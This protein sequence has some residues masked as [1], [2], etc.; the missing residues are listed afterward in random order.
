M[1]VGVFMKLAALFKRVTSV[2]LAAVLTASLFPAPLVALAQVRAQE[3]EQ[4]SSSAAAPRYNLDV[5]VGA[6]VAQVTVD[7]S[8]DGVP[9]IYEEDVEGSVV[10]LPDENYVPD[11]DL[12]AAENFVRPMV[13][14]E[15]AEKGLSVFSSEMAIALPSVSSTSGKVYK[16]ISSVELYTILD[17][18]PQLAEELPTGALDNYVAY[19]TSAH[20]PSFFA[21]LVSTTASSVTVRE[22]FGGQ[23]TL[24]F[25]LA[26][27]DNG[28]STPDFLASLASL[29]GYQEGRATA[30]GN[31]VKLS[32]FLDGSAVIQAGN[33]LQGDLATK[34]VRA[35][36]AFDASGAMVSNRDMAAASVKIVFD[37]RSVLGGTVSG[38]S[39]SV[40]GVSVPY[41]YCGYSL[42][43][44][45][46]AVARVSDHIQA[47]AYLDYFSAFT[48]ANLD[49]RVQREYWVSAVQANASRVARDILSNSGALI[50]T[51]PDNKVY[52]ALLDK[53]LGT[54]GTPAELKMMSLL[55]TYNYIQRWYDFDVEGIHVA[56][57]LLFGGSYYGE[58]CT[59][60]GLAARFAVSQPSQ[61]KGQQTQ[62]GY[63]QLIYPCLRQG[64]AIANVK[65]FVEDI[66]DVFSDFETADDWFV[67]EYNKTG[68]V[69]EGK[70]SEDGFSW[71]A[72][73]NLSK[74][75]TSGHVRNGQ[76]RILPFLTLPDYSYYAF[77][78][79][80]VFSYGSPYMYYTDPSTPE[81]QAAL[82]ARVRKNQQLQL[83]YIETIVGFTGR[84]AMWNAMLFL[85]QDKQI[86]NAWYGN[87]AWQAWWGENGCTEANATQDPMIKG[88]YEALQLPPPS[89]GSAACGG[90][91]IVR[92]RCNAKLDDF[93]VWSHEFGHCIDEKIL[94]GGATRKDVA[95][96]YTFGMLE[97][98]L[99]SSAFGLNIAYDSPWENAYSMNASFKSLRTSDSAK[100]FYGGLFELIDIL[101]YLELKAFLRLSTA[102]QQA[103]ATQLW[104]GGDNRMTG[105]YGGP[106]FILYDPASVSKFAS[107]MNVYVSDEAKA[108]IMVDGE[109]VRH[110]DTI[111]EV[112]DHRVCLIPNVTATKHPEWGPSAYGRDTILSRWWYLP[113]HNNGGSATAVYKSLSF[114]MA[115]EAGYYGF[116]QMLA[117]N[118][119]DT[120]ALRNATG[121]QDFK[122]YKLDT[123][124]EIEERLDELRWIDAD[125]LEERYLAAFKSAAAKGDRSLTEANNI[126]L[127]SFALLKRLTRDF[128]DTLFSPT[129]EATHIA[130]AADLAKIVE[131][132][133]GAFVL[134]NDIRVT[135]EEGA[136]FLVDANFRG[137]FNGQGHSITG[138]LLPPLF[139]EADRATVRDLTINDSS[140]ST[141]AVKMSNVNIWNVNILVRDTSIAISNVEEFLAM[142]N[143][144]AA[145][146][147]I[148]ADIDFSDHVVAAAGSALIAA[149]FTGSLVGDGHVLSGLT[150][151]SLFTKFKGT[152]R[153]LQIRDFTNK[154]VN[155]DYIA[156]FAKILTGA[157]IENISFANIE[158]AGKYRTAVLCGHDDSPSAIS[159]VSVVNSTVTGQD[160][161]CYNSLLVGR[162]NGGTMTDVHVQ[163]QLICQGTENGGVCGSAKATVFTRCVA[164]VDITRLP[165]ATEERIQSAGFLGNFDNNTACTVK[166]CAFVG[167]ADGECYGFTG[168]TDANKRYFTDCYE[169]EG[170]QATSAVNG[171]NIKTLSRSDAVA[172]QFWDGLGY[173]QGLWSYADISSGNPMLVFS[174]KAWDIHMSIDYIA[175]TMTLRGED[176]ENLNIDGLWGVT[177]GMTSVSLTQALDTEGWD[178]RVTI[179]RAD[180]G[181][182]GVGYSLSIDIPPRPEAPEVIAVPAQSEDSRAYLTYPVGRSYEVRSVD[183]TSAW[184]AVPPYFCGTPTSTSPVVKEIRCPAVVGQSFV[185]KVTTV[186]L[187][188]QGNIE[189][190]RY[191][192]TFETNGGQLIDAPTDYL[193]GTTL[194]L[195]TPTLEGHSFV[196]WYDNDAFAGS[197][198]AMIEATDT[199]DKTFWAEWVANVYHVT[200]E[201]NGGTLKSGANDL[202][203]H[204]YG[205]VATLPELER[206]GYD[207][208]GWYA[209]ANLAGNAVTTIAATDMGDKFFWAKWI[210]RAYAITYDRGSDPNG[211]TPPASID[212]T[213]FGQYQTG[214]TFSLPGSDVMV[215]DG[216]T[217]AGW[218]E[219]SSLVGSP[220]T[221]I[222][223]GEHGDRTF[224]AK[225]VGEA[226]TISYYENGGTF[227]NEPETFFE[228]G[229]GGVQTGSV[230]TLPTA[231]DI[232]RQGYAFD[233]WYTD[234]SLGG[235]S[236]ASIVLEHGNIQLYAK[237]APVSYTI[238]YELNGG[239]WAAGYAPTESYTIESGTV[240]LPTYEAIVREGFV[241]SGWFSDASLAG[242]ASGIIASGTTGDKTFWAK[243]DEGVVVPPDDTEDPIEPPD[244]DEP[245]LEIISLTFDG[246]GGRRIEWNDDGYARIEVPRSKA[247]T[248]A[249]DFELQVPEGVECVIQKRGVPFIFV[250]AE[251]LSGERDSASEIWDILLRSKTDARAAHEKL[252]SLEIVPVDDEEPG[253]G[254]DG[255]GD[256]DQDPVEPPTTP[257]PDDTPDTDPGD[258]GPDPDDGASGGDQG[259]DDTPGTDGDDSNTDLGDGTGDGMPGADDP[260]AAPAGS[261]G[262]GSGS[263]LADTRDAAAGRGAV[264]CSVGL[265]AVGLA[266]AALRRRRQAR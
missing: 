12:Q 241:F 240:V 56:D 185:S 67:Y 63:A 143:N 204:T 88:F 261:G 259:S 251:L 142:A 219:D 209:N 102:D 126:R 132:P 217:F 200:L 130:T 116:Q 94:C 151:A 61:R 184:T 9:I 2:M 30:Y 33:A 109:T 89:G 147:R 86:V 257:D 154:N 193:A 218:Y 139:R 201:K 77:S 104:Y 75:G 156:A 238:S 58:K 43:D 55:Y 260:T 211:D 6:D 160:A 20:A 34:V 192:L 15:A 167:T 111:E 170:V 155:G 122:Q 153:D 119:N 7:L 54:E 71:R 175:E 13:A 171:T 47:S 169:V 246:L 26:T 64:A 16:D 182:H 101:D 72:W 177:E 250:L 164:D 69:E 106:T 233:G 120:L 51:A 133:C 83:N 129:T 65:G 221:Q 87:Y 32:P 163:G 74:D 149:D 44:A 114:R 19:V 85:D 227:V 117:G 183:S 105:D 180:D 14:S 131:N 82:R 93:L 121:K 37:D 190:T 27:S 18:T 252:Y 144:P 229:V 124:A 115:G 207:F 22:P 166:Q 191:Q 78:L 5:S 243:W 39:L 173:L 140:G 220:I 162:K 232:Q 28:E 97:Q 113:H 197:S 234:A 135:A 174:G 181:D 253:P 107:S 35:V 202:T 172:Q 91:E 223:A 187:R 40:G 237:W 263:P 11:M 90:N 8:E 176:A 24:P 186:D 108:D 159:R 136:S 81:N 215:W 41:E 50:A 73:T 256:D 99:S 141:I 45:N 214:T 239:A 208:G 245:K 178:H 146:Y 38:E 254:V 92:W 138:D 68:V 95:E 110:F 206:E 76:R 125:E 198:I 225:W 36:L 230:L 23:L 196:G 84:K 53:A 60:D 235:S 145:D 128:D 17:G 49:N 148:V 199:G 10:E 57:L 70:P 242:G 137:Y 66:V 226:C 210:P 255:D 150:N 262:D 29:S 247:P 112:F 127:Q 98:G 31:I 52:A 161:G 1:G 216:H 25:P 168:V 100:Q 244:A 79:P 42:G 48:D 96:C 158:L 59:I 118:W 236:L 165:S 134:D 222:A 213:A 103:V 46:A 248:K 203:I 264:V 179:T 258:D 231:A 152:A 4:T 21:S 123:Y 205:Q 3:P 228:F 212:L 266:V 62:I 224:Y 80:S 265:A 249:E 194:E 195:P 157:T 188:Y 189:P